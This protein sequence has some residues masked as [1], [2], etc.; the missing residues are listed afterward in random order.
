MNDSFYYLTIVFLYWLFIISA[1]LNVAI[2]KVLVFATH[3]PFFCFGIFGS[4][5]SIIDCH[6]WIWSLFSSDLM[7]PRE[8]MVYLITS[9]FYKLQE[10]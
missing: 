4:Q 7:M 3:F 9:N 5:E 1:S 6:V 2:L 10:K 8:S